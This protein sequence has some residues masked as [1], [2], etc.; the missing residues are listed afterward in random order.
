MVPSSAGKIA[1][2]AGMDDQSCTELLRGMEQKGLLFSSE[3]NG[4]TRYMA[5]QFVVG[6]WEYH[7][8]SLDEELI[9]D[10]NEYFPVLFNGKTWKDAPQLRTIPVGKSLAVDHQ[11]LPYEHAEQLIEGKRKYLVAPCICRKEHTL[12][13]KGCDKPE[14]A[15]L[16]FDTAADFYE[17]RG[18][19][20]VIDQSE[21]LQILDSAEEHGLVLQPSNAKDALSIC[22]CCGCCCQ[23]LQMLKRQPRPADSFTS[24]FIAQTQ[25]DNCIGCELCLQRCPMDALS[26][27]DQKAVVDK[28]RCIGCGLC[29]PTCPSDALNMERSERQPN[30]PKDARG[31]LINLIK[32]RKA[33]D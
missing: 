11:A 25:P 26:M 15:C 3:R 27:I 33:Q 19:G 23:V 20:R 31:S 6:I 24:A 7:V 30:V 22:L 29:V 18:I 5:A 1:A 13:G 9:K 21:T 8:N 12:L 32:V 4:E 16:L 28:G 2:R 14:E 17:K 10:A